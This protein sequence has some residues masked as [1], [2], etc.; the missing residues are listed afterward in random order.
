MTTKIVFFLS[1]F[2]YNFEAT[3]TSFSKVIKKSQKKELRF[4]LL[5]LLVIKRS[6]PRSNGSGSR[7]L[8]TYG[9]CGSES[10]SATLVET[11]LK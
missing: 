9:S 6:A 10:G 11:N 8:K 7:S 2:A 4:F 1:L 5:I 3:F